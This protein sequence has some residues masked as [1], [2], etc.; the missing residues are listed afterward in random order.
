[1][2]ASQV[3]NNNK[4]SR[5]LDHF[6]S[7]YNWR[8]YIQTKYEGLFPEN[9]PTNQDFK[10]IREE[11]QKARIQGDPNKIIPKLL[12]LK[13]KLEQRIKSIGREWIRQQ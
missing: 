13:A 5:L 10:S 2:K 6:A 7:V 11:M 3:G 4:N 9:F 12:A 8:S 1:M